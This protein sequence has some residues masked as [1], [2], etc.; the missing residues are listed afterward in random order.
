MSKRGQVPSHLLSWTWTAPPFK[1]CRKM[2]PRA[3]ACCS[4]TVYS[5]QS[6]VHSAQSTVHSAQCTVHSA[7]CDSAQCSCTVHSAQCRGA[8]CSCTPAP[9]QATRQCPACFETT[10]AKLYIHPSSSSTHAKLYIHHHQHHHPANI[11]RRPD[12]KFEQHR[13]GWSFE[14]A[15]LFKFFMVL[16]W[17]WHGHTI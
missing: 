2:D 16:F 12:D 14:M 3:G 5:T 4:C 1:S 10:H 9:F 7:Q 13:R 6:T 8:C 11:N 15:R 17:F